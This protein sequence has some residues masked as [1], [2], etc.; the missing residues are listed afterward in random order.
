[1]IGRDLS[2]PRFQAFPS[3]PCPACARSNLVFDRQNLRRWPSK[4]T[5]YGV[6]EGYLLRGDEAGV[7]SALMKCSDYVCNQGVAVLGNYSIHIVGGNY[8]TEITF[9]VCDIYLSFALI[10]MPGAVTEQIRDALQRSFGLYWRDPQ[11]CAAALRTAIEGIADKLGQP[12][13]QKGKF[14]PL[15]KRLGRIQASHSDLV[16]AAEAIKDFGNEG[17]HGGNVLQ[18]KLLYAFEL[19]EIELRRIFNDV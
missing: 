19:L 5:V 17:A 3:W 15:A 14:V 10:D 2:E 6:E 16:D 11:S 4:G 9:T 8:N 12:A 1:M 13:K 7:F 18:S